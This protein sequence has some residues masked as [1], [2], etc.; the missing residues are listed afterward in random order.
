MNCLRSPQVV[1][2]M[3][4]R[5]EQIN[6]VVMRQASNNQTYIVCISFF[7]IVASLI[8]FKNLFMGKYMELVSYVFSV[9]RIICEVQIIKVKHYY[10]KA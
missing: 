10:S 4:S 6:R 2:P 8:I 3:I 1:R 9:Q 7:F 5:N